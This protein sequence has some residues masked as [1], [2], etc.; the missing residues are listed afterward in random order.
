[1]KSPCYV[2][3]TVIFQEEDDGRWTAECQELGTATFGH[4][5]SDARMKI[6]EAIILHLNALE[7]V[8]ERDR[9]FRENG[10]RIAKTTQL[11][12]H[13]TVDAPLD[14]RIFIHPFVQSMPVMEPC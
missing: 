11:P 8:G 12:T 5:L 14:P 1:M 2:Q 4:S 9:F 3:L 7:Q 6:E 13:V 10:I